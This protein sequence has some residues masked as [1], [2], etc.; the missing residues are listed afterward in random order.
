MMVYSGV[1]PNCAL[2]TLDPTE[3][4]TEGTAAFPNTLSIDGERSSRFQTPKPHILI[5][6]LVMS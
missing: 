4:S 5:A 6:A 1:G 2:M 3:D